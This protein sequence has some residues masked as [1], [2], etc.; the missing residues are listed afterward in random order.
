METNV[1]VMQKKEAS[2]VGNIKN[3]NKFNGKFY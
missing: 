3:S 1:N 2:T